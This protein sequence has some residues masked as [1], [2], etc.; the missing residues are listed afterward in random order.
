MKRR[1]KFEKTIVDLPLR[2]MPQAAIHHF[3][4]GEGKEGQWHSIYSEGE[5]V[6][7]API[8]EKGKIVLVSM[9]RFPIESW[10]FELPGGDQGPEEDMADTARRELWEE[11][12]Y[13]A[14]EFELLTSG[15]VFSG[16]SNA[17][18]TTFSALNCRR[19]AEPTLDDV[20]KYAGLEVVEVYPG[21]VMS[22][23]GEGCPDYDLPI[24]SAP[25]V[26]SGKG[27]LIF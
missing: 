15:W 26:L 18:F 9:F 19:V 21:E 14:D 1:P 2:F 17:H 3:P 7:V 16:K 4:L 27:V 10:F 13:E 6:L 24:H 5:T 22:K 8:T 25:L 23:I 12:G 20:E 11:T